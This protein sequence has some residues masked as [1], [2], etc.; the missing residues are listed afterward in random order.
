MFQL[1]DFNS[2]LYTLYLTKRNLV[3]LHLTKCLVITIK[4]KD[5]D[6]VRLY[7]EP[8]EPTPA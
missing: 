6:T 5:E 1:F 8:I 3:N 2:N 7:F 4:F